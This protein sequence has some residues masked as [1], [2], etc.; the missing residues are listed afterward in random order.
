MNGS[1]SSREGRERFSWRGENMAMQKA[2]EVRG[3]SDGL[4][5]ECVHVWE[6]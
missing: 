2:V 1:L 5:I 4:N 3:S 6:Q